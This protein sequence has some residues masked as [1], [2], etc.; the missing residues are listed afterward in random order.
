M[1]DLI[2]EFDKG[3][4]KVSLPLSE[5]SENS[6]RVRVHQVI[7][8]LQ[9]LIRSDVAIGTKDSEERAEKNSA[10][11]ALDL[12]CQIHLHNAKICAERIRAIA[13]GE[14]SISE[15][16]FPEFGDSGDMYDD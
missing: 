2:I 6:V 13:D 14:A 10:V 1:S 9:S 3:M 16:G 11:L 8:I 5:V 4:V 12:S 15:Y 7:P